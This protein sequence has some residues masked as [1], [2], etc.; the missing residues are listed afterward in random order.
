MDPC[1]HPGGVGTWLGRCGGGL[2]LDRGFSAKPA[3]PHRSHRDQVSIQN[4]SPNPLW[5]QDRA[6]KKSGTMEALVQ[7]EGVLPV[8]SGTTD[9]ADRRQLA[10]VHSSNPV[11]GLPTPRWIQS[12]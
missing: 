2:G 10:L 3:K 5:G 7:G 12:T 8:V 1:G 6:S 4:A 9:G 11:V